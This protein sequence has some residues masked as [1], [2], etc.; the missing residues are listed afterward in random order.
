MRVLLTEE[1]KES[2][3]AKQAK[4]KGLRSIGFGRWVD[5]NGNMAAFTNKRGRLV[6]YEPTEEKPEEGPK[7]DGEDGTSTFIKP[8]IPQ[9]DKKLLKPYQSKGYVAPKVR[10]KRLNH[11]ELRKQF[12]HYS[13]KYSAEAL[14]VLLKWIQNGELNS[15]QMKFYT[16]K[17]FLVYAPLMKDLVVSLNMAL[18]DAGGDESGLVKKVGSQAVFDLDSLYQRSSVPEKLLHIMLLDL[19]QRGPSY[20]YAKSMSLSYAANAQ[21]YREL[22]K[23]LVFDY[24]SIEN[25]VDY[26]DAQ[27]LNEPEGDSTTNYTKPTGDSGVE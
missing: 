3:A 27:G 13:S 18:I 16:G 6:P 14:L 19:K 21:D 22:S 23:I 1:E 10:V 4:L 9:G 25:E 11:D 24:D 20:I 7:G 2:E 5:K 8:F 12:D 26:D 17:E 15:H